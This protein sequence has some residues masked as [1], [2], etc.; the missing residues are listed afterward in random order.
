MP[1]KDNKPSGTSTTTNESRERTNFHIKA[2]TIRNIKLI[3]LIQNKSI[4][5]LAETA[6][7]EFVSRW[8]VQHGPLP[9]IP[10]QQ[11]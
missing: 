3:A 10:K 2:D 7:Q 9:E 5:D 11:D 1:S 4:T 6:L 8:E